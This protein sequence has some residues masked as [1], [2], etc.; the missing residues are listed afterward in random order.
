[1]QTQATLFDVMPIEPL[2]ARNTGKF[3]DIARHQRRLMTQCGSSNLRVV[4][5]DGRALS[6][7][8]NA[9][10]GGVRGRARPDRR[11]GGFQPALRRA[12]MAPNDSSAIKASA[13]EPGSGTPFVGAV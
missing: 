7:Q 4:R 13:N 1:M 5:A 2:Q 9:K 11:A 8:V 6:L 12:P 10:S 3:A